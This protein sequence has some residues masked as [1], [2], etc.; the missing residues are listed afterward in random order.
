MA[1]TPVSRST[2]RASVSRDLRDPTNASFTT[3]EVNDLINQA[4]VEVGRIYPKQRVVEYAVSVDQQEQFVCDA[5]AIFRVEVVQD[6]QVQKGVPA[7]TVSE[8]GQTGWDLHGGLLWLPYFARNTL[9]AADSPTVRV[10]GYWDRVIPSA[11]TDTMDTDA[12]AEYAVRTYATLL[13]YQRLQNDRMLFQQ[14][15]TN[16]GNTDIS[17]NQLAQTAD[18][19]QSQWREMRQR[20]RYLQRT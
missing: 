18:L 5:A 12:E 16:T 4:M 7:S 15:L 3:Q 20:L 13:G 10:W 14:W 17:P 11:D 8:H 1:Y 19:Y 9:V 6:G 2:L